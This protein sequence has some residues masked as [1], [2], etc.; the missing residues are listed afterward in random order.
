MQLEQLL[1]TPPA[2][3]GSYLRLID[4]VY[5][6]TL[7]LR[8]IKKTKKKGGGVYERAE[9]CWRGRSARYSSI[10]TCR[11]LREAICQGVAFSLGSGRGW[12]LT[13][14]KAHRLVYHSTLGL[15]VIQKRR[16]RLTWRGRRRGG[17]VRRPASRHST[18]HS[19]RASRPPRF[20]TLLG[21]DLPGP[22]TVCK[23]T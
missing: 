18:P 7:G 23:P 15:R 9:R 19:R 12:G 1:V 3:A 21:T 6:S 22:L 13:C 8:V 20:G 4:C 2:E 10:P 5:H 11:C 16:R 17:G 14:R